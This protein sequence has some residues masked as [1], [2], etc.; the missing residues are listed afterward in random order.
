MGV[1]FFFDEEVTAQ[2]RK[3]SEAKCQIEI[4]DN[5]GTPEVRI[6]PQGEAHN[7]TIAEFNDWAQFERFVDAVNRLHRRLEPNKP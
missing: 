4:A 6:G 2:E 3:N 5:H 1:L 7:G